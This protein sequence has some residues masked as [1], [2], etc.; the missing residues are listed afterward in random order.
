MINIAVCEDDVFLGGQIE[1]MLYRQAEAAGVVIETEVLTSAEQCLKYIREEG[2]V[3]LLLLDIELGKMNGIELAAIIRN[4]LHNDYMQIVYVSSKQ[5]YAMELFESRPLHFLVKPLDEEKLAKVFRKA[6]KLIDNSEET[7]CYKKGYTY[8]KV[9]LSEIIYFEANN[10]EVIMH[11]VSGTDTFYGTLKS[12]YP[13]L[14]KH[15]FFFCHKSFL[16]HYDKVKIFETTQLIMHNEDVIS[17]SQG[18]RKAVKELQ[19]ER[20]MRYL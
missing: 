16:V 4:E 3:D 2:M 18:Q 19:L 20:E 8:K 10:R 9:F 12:I 6:V 13:E 7:F 5:S 14:Q 1:T 11:T 15:G 17:I